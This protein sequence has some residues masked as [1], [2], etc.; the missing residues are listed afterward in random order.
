MDKEK[1]EEQVIKMLAD[2][3]MRDADTI[4]LGDSFCYDLDMDN[5]Q[6]LGFI[7]DIENHFNIAILDEEIEDINENDVKFLVALIS[8]L[9]E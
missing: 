5:S 8:R 9:K 7:T 4:S 1:I 2:E 3:L 6:F